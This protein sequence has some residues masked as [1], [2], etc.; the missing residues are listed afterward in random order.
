M[1]NNIMKMFSDSKNP[2]Q[3]AKNYL[4]Y[5]K[6]VIDAIDTT[7]VGAFIELLLK[8]RE[9]GNTVF[10][11]GNGGSAATS[12]HFANDLAIGT[13]TTKKHFRVMSLTDN[14]A[15]LTALGNDDGY[16]S[17]F[18]RQ[19]SVFMKPGDTIVAL[20]ASGNSQNIINAVDYAKTN[21]AFVVGVTGFSGGKLKELCD[22]SL[23]VQTPAGEYGP[24]EDLHMIFD[25]LVGAYLLNLVKAEK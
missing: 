20:S 13:R 14:V 9:N 17:I 3:F 23:H 15:V 11:V 18:V 10:F 4:S 2:A 12:S 7:K 22:L 5:L 16:D 8:N 25:H 6:T 24:V 21:G 1:Q 19:L